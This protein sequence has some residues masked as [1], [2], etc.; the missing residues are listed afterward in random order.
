MSVVVTEDIFVDFALDMIGL[1]DPFTKEHCRETAELASNIA[2]ALSV[3]KNIA[4]SIR[5]AAFLHDVG[6]QAIPKEIL[7][8]PGKLSDEEYNLVKTHVIQGLT[9]MQNVKLD[10][11]A[12]KF[13]S[14]HHERLDGSGYPLGLSQPYLSMGGQIVGVADVISAL[15]SKRTYRKPM[16]LEGVIAILYDMKGTHFSEEIVT[17]AIQVM[18]DH[19]HQLFDD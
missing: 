2:S 17:A 1:N 14:E 8:K 3:P 10:R 19:G 11:E 12:A 7:S 5:V 6:K 15:T 9:L 18:Y 16:K 13:I 4:K